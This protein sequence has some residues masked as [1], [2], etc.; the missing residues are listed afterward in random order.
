MR[1]SHAHG[2]FG[3]SE[4]ASRRPAHRPYLPHPDP[5]SITR[6]QETN[7]LHEPAD[8]I[9]RQI[10]LGHPVSPAR[11]GRRHALVGRLRLPVRPRQVR[12]ANQRAL[13]TVAASAQSVA[14]RTL[15]TPCQIDQRIRR[16][17]V[18]SCRG[19]CTRRLGTG[20][21]LIRA[22]VIGRPP[23]TNIGCRT[24]APEANPGKRE[25]PYESVC[26]P[27]AGFEP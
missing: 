7:P 25:N 10:E 24:I 13:R 6:F 26:S 11:N 1:S 3:T 27:H 19:R 8:H 22:V 4:R 2:T 14:S 15:C 9:G 12:C 16:V 23:L 21:R 17:A 5:K 20:A 18:R